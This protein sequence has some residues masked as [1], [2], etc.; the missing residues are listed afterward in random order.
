MIFPKR[1]SPLDHLLGKV[2]KAYQISCLVCDYH[3]HILVIKSHAEEPF[4]EGHLG[5]RTVKKLPKVCPKC[6]GRHLHVI[7]AP[8]PCD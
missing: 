1:Y 4:I 7:E 8:K 2:P 5:M 3:E 6:G